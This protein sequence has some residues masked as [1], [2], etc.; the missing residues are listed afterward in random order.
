M[1]KH[2]ID[3]LVYATTASAARTRELTEA[4]DDA[5]DARKRALVKSLADEVDTLS[6]LLARLSS[7][8]LPDPEPDAEEQERLSRT[9]VTLML[10]TVEKRMHQTRCETCGGLR[11]GEPYQGIWNAPPEKDGAAM[12]RKLI[13]EAK[14]RRADDADD[15]EPI[16]AEAAKAHWNANED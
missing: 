16:S 4:L 13:A 9:M 10:M 3:A 7:F 14:Q 5:P 6:S 1:S 15:F 8:E 11:K 2:V 12:A